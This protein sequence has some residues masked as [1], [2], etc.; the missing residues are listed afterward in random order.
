MGLCEPDEDPAVMKAYYETVTDMEAYDAY[1][2]S[3]KK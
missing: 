1:L 2:A 3:K